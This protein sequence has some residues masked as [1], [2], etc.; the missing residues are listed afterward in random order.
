M[1]KT[2]FLGIRFLSYYNIFLSIFFIYSS[3]MLITLSQ[4]I[5]E[6]DGKIFL[7]P[8]IFMI[9]LSLFFVY[10]AIMYLLRKNIERIMLICSCVFQ[11]IY[12]IQGTIGTYRASNNFS[13]VSIFM[14]IVACWGIW[15]LRT[16]EATDWV[17]IVK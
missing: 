4:T 2:S 12:S 17:A 1:K 3:V 6:V 5:D 16:K 7:P 14:L 9:L 10:S 8:I 13:L 15:F 11:A